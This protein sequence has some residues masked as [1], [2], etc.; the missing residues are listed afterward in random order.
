LLAAE[1][2]TFSEELTFDIYVSVDIYFNSDERDGDEILQKNLMRIRSLF[3]CF[4][5]E[6]EKDSIYLYDDFKQDIR[7]PDRKYYNLS[8]SL[9]FDGLNSQALKLLETCFNDIMQFWNHRH[10]GQT[11]DLADVRTRT[12]KAGERP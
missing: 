4:D 3:A 5:I 8:S 7:F 2:M 11:M 9:S 1:Y 6:V 10:S 12:Y